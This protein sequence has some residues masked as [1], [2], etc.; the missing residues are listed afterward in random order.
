[1][2]QSRRLPPQ[3][4]GKKESDVKERSR[5]RTVS[6][7][8]PSLSPSPLLTRSALNSFRLLTM[9]SLSLIAYS[10]PWGERSESALKECSMREWPDCRGAQKGGGKSAFVGGKESEGK[11]EEGEG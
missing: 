3:T 2:S 7:L 11:Q 6:L 4:L 8:S 1:M 5:Q 9:K 10:S